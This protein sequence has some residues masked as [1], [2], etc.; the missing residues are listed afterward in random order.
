MHYLCSMDYSFWY[1]VNSNGAYLAIFRD[2]FPDDAL[3]NIWASTL[4][5]CVKGALE[6]IKSYEGKI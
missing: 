6:L 2:D 4:D 3:F 1:K 5:A